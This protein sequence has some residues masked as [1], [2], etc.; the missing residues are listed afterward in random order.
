MAS[1]QLQVQPEAGREAVVAT[2]NV[3][4]L[5]LP[6]K[7]YSQGEEVQFRRDLEAQL[8]AIELELR[9]VNPGS[10]PQ[11]SLASKRESMFSVQIGVQEYS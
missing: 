5:N 10:S 2:R 1:G 3:G 7:E 4:R 9:S 6:P 8:T 11:G